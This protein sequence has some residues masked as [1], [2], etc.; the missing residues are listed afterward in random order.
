ML[1]TVLMLLPQEGCIRAGIVLQKGK[2]IDQS[3]EVA[4][5]HGVTELTSNSLSMERDNCEEMWWSTLEGMEGC[6]ALPVLPEQQSM[7]WKE[8][9]QRQ[10]QTSCIAVCGLKCDAPWCRC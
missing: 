1:H 6:L 10:E 8:L 7:R 9:K 4:S 2:S 5:I 3:C